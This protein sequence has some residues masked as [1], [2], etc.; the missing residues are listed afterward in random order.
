LK[1]LF[2][3]L[4]LLLQ[5]GGALYAGDI[6]EKGYGST[7]DQA[8][9]EAL[10]AL[11]MQIY[12]E[13]KSEFK[14]SVT[15]EN[16]GVKESVIKDIDIRSDLPLLGVQYQVS[17][18]KDGYLAIATL[19]YDTVSLYETQVR[20]IKS[21]FE[22]E[23]NRL[24]KIDSDLD[25]LHVYN[26]LL[27]YLDMYLKYRVV[28]YFLGSRDISDLDLSEGEIRSMIGRLTQKSNSLDAGL[29]LAALEFDY[30]NIYVFPPTTKNTSEITQF[31]AAVKG[32][33]DVYLDTAIS[34]KMAEYFLTGEYQVL[35][36]G[37]ELVFRLV[38]KEHNTIKTTISG[39]V[40]DA[41]KDY[42]TEPHTVDFDMLLKSGLFLSGELRPNIT[43]TSG[44][45]DLL[46]YEGDSFNITVK[47][48][49][50]GYFYLVAH[51]FRHDEEYSYL[52]DF[53][54]SEGDSKFL[55]FINAD[56]VN[57]W[58]DIGEFQ[59]VPPFGVES[60]QLIASTGDLRAKVPDTYYDQTTGLYK[61]GEAPVEAVSQTR[62]LIR[63]T[64]KQ[65]EAG[66]EKTEYAETTLTITTMSR[67]D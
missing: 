23:F 33:M 30:N 8:R 25:K 50:P 52:V 19:D 7:E 14:S 17:K 48:N 34:T 20:S 39:F 60:L 11:G 64:R 38:D 24:S 12:V 49:R 3:I 61:L 45:R 15:R 42:G 31:G 26:K 32:R 59:V 66:E 16:Q 43:T 22:K 27:T 21:S 57:R 37:L 46:F 2:I 53:Y 40:P 56:Q 4:L 9:K 6:F 35:N 18:V 29:K 51:T 65:K 47:M 28:A 5:W 63:K 41:Y 55:Y 67:R 1:R 58:L 44:S 10:A 54:D 13:V 36:D 62:G